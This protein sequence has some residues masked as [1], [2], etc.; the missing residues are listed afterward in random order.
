M[1]KPWECR[2]S[3]TCPYP[4]TCDI[5]LCFFYFQIR[6][7]ERTISITLIFMKARNL[8]KGIRLE[9]TLLSSSDNKHIHVFVS[10]PLSRVPFR[11]SMSRLAGEVKKNISIANSVSRRRRVLTSLVI[12]SRDRV[13]H[14]GYTAD[15]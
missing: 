10:R 13:A 15:I 1:S 5:V 8:N 14:S 11:Y 12:N 3:V 9:R 4:G 2:Y 7:Q 6:K